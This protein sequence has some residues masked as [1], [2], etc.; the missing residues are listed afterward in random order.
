MF[1]C[2]GFGSSRCFALITASRCF[3]FLPL[4]FARN[5]RCPSDAEYA[6]A[7]TLS[8]RDPASRLS[9][10]VGLDHLAPFMAM[11]YICPHRFIAASQW[12]Y[13]PLIQLPFLSFSSWPPLRSAQQPTLR[14]S[15]RFRMFWMR[16]AS[17]QP[18]LAFSGGVGRLD[19]K[20]GVTLIDRS[21]AIL[22][23]YQVRFCRVYA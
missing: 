17:F 2:D 7:C 6:V 8:N 1:S 4:A 5:Y 13:C 9:C 14:N 10:V 16:G 12:R 15:H 22:R 18:T 19:L 11:A 21:L 23:R 20:G 3:L